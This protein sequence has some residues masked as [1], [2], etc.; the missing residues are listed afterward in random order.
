MRVYRVGTT[1]IDLDHVVAIGDPYKSYNDCGECMMV[2]PTDMSFIGKNNISIPV[3]GEGFNGERYIKNYYSFSLQR[4]PEYN[5]F[6]D[7][8]FRQMKYNIWAP[9]LKAWQNK[10]K[11]KVE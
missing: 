10:E 11:V 5:L 6:L 2:I 7:A 1:Y 3:S 8:E 9:F 4:T